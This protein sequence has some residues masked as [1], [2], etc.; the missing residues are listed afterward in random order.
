MKF[1]GEAIHTSPRYIYDFDLCANTIELVRLMEQIN[2]NHYYLCCVTQD[3]AGIY[4]VIFR[5]PKGE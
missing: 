2:R 1:Y 5:R 4:T 3:S